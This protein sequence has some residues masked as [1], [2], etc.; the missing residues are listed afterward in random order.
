MGAS[1]IDYRRQP[2]HGRKARGPCLLPGLDRAAGSQG[3][4]HDGSQMRWAPVIMAGAFIVIYAALSIRSRS[5][6]SWR[7]GPYPADPKVGPGPA[8][9]FSGFGMESLPPSPAVLC[10]IGA[11]FHGPGCNCANDRTQIVYGPGSEPRAPAVQPKTI[12]VAGYERTTKSRQDVC[13]ECALG[14]GRDPDHDPMCPG[15]VTVYTE[16]IKIH[17]S[18]GCEVEQEEGS[19]QDALQVAL[20]NHHCQKREKARR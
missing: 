7:N 6:R 20:A 9:A 3:A 12:S 19:A 5:W 15:D 8:E 16:G 13:P 14:Q 17:L 4:A 10:G 1:Q 18:C 11:P 2:G